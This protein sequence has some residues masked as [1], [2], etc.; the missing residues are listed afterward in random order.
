MK[1]DNCEKETEM[2]FEVIDVV[3]FQSPIYKVCYKCKNEL[4]MGTYALTGD[5][6]K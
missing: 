3:D 5:V 6:I 4:C 1:C 2:Y